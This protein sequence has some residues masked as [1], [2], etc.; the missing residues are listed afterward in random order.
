MNRAE[1]RHLSDRM[2]VRAAWPRNTA[3]H[4]ARVIDV[5][6]NVAWRIAKG[7]VPRRLDERIDEA[8]TRQIEQNLAEMR[9]LLDERSALRT[10]R[11]LA[12]HQDRIR[13]RQGDGEPE[14]P[15]L[16]ARSSDASVGEGGG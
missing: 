6:S 4:V 9:R 13:A 7:I 1:N 5:T 2:F 12:R 8:A 11:A 3:K 16:V 14:I 15:G 10:R